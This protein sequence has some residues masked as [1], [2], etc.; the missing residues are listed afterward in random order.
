MLLPIS[1]KQNKVSNPLTS[2]FD[3][4]MTLFIFNL[5]FKGI[6]LSI[7]L[8]IILQHFF[9]FYHIPSILN[10]YEYFRLENILVV[11]SESLDKKFLNKLKIIYGQV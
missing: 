9:L 8:G 7:M 11:I 4:K 2:I 1:V 10:R 5:S 3:C 6:S